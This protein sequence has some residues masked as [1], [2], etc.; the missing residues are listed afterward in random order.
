MMWSSVTI[1]GKPSILLVD[2]SRNF[3][4]WERDFC[5][6]LHGSLKRAGLSIEGNEPIRIAEA[7]EME[8]YRSKQ[9]NCWI[10]FAHGTAS[11]VPT[12]RTLRHHWEQLN[13]HRDF[14]PVLFAG[15]M[16][17]SYDA[18]TSELILKSSPSIAA[19]ALAPQSQATARESSLFLLKFFVELNLHSDES[20]T[21]KMAWF[22]FTKA[23]ELL[24]RRRYSGLFGARC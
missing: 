6:R 14:P 20:I 24:R 7:G 21:G 16:F 3:R 23:R 1:P 8:M 5:E 17:D 19:I 2:A 10:Y 9:S 4:G 12:E 15:M 11:N 13:Q 18:P 22:S